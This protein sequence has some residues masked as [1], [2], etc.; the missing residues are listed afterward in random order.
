MTTP[1]LPTHL[2]EKIVCNLDDSTSFFSALNE[3][4]CTGRSPFLAAFCEAAA[5]CPPWRLWPKLQ[6]FA[7]EPLASEALVERVLRDHPRVWLDTTCLVAYVY[8]MSPTAQLQLAV[9]DDEIIDT[10]LLANVTDLHVISTDPQ[11]LVPTAA[12]LANAPRVRTL[13]LAVD[14][15][16]VLQNDDLLDVL[17]ASLS[18]SLESLVFLFDGDLL[19]ELSD[20]VVMR[21]AQLIVTFPVSMVRF[22]SVRTSNAGARTLFDALRNAPSLDKINFLSCDQLVSMIA[23]FSQPRTCLRYHEHDAACVAKVA[24]SSAFPTMREWSMSTSYREARPVYALLRAM[25]RLHHIS[26]SCD[27][28]DDVYMYPVLLADIATLQNL[29]SLAFSAERLLGNPDHAAQLFLMLRELPN[30][31]TLRLICAGTTTEGVIVLAAVLS[32]L[33]HLHHIDLSENFLGDA[34][35]PVLEHIIAMPQLQSLWLACNDLSPEAKARLGRYLQ[36]LDRSPCHLALDD[37]QQSFV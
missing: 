27:S 2:L 29:R 22:S 13:R 21:V 8:M 20:V 30:L 36:Q 7:H 15:G 35:V 14:I 5:V 10:T 26:V 34:A 11:L 18:P 23:A 28:D 25:P 32:R 3:L 24:Q 31:A 17:S 4:P 6:I 1:E 16:V 12:R 19:D 33:P 37:Y 9:T